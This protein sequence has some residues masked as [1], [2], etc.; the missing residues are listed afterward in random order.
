MQDLIFTTD[1]CIGCNRCIAA[2]P[3]LN[4][5][6]VVEREDKTQYIHVDASKCMACGA[7]LDACEHKA[8]EFLDDTQQLMEDLKRGQAVS[9]LYAPALTANYPGEYKNILSGT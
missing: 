1:K 2:C 6:H 7:C 3:V 5:N 9:V 4:A 8:R